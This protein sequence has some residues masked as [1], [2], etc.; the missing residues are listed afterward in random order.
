M[1]TVFPFCNWKPSVESRALDAALKSQGTNQREGRVHANH[2]NVFPSIVYFSSI[3]R[4]KLESEEKDLYYSTSALSKAKHVTF[5]DCL[6][7]DNIN[8]RSTIKIPPF[9]YRK[10]QLIVTQTCNE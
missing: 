4:K 7:F 10:T 3:F 2:F 8:F 5:R 9:H 1:L 6:T